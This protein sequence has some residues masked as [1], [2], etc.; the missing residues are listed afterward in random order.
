M[1][2]KTLEIKRI[3]NKSARQIT[4]SKRRNGLMKKAMELS[5]L[6]DAQVAVVIFSS[7]GRLFE[8]CNGESLDKVLQRYWNHLRESRTD[9]KELCFEITDIWSDAA[10]SQ[11][12]KRHFGVSELEHL[13]LTDLLELETL[14]HTALSQIRSAKM[15]LVM[16][17]VVNLKKQNN[18]VQFDSSKLS[19]CNALNFRL[20]GG[21]VPA[22]KLSH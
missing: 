6:C 11:L 8:R 7:T 20:L 19:E 3:E 15:R 5:V 12:V 2:K 1:G 10:F 4:F 9:K 14:I 21:E 22:Y 18:M 17:S 13:T 16:E